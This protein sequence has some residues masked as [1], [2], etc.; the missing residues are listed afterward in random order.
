MEKIVVTHKKD[1]CKVCPKPS[2]GHCTF[3]K[4]TQ[5]CSNECLSFDWDA[6]HKEFCIGATIDT[7]KNT[8]DGIMAF[9]WR[10]LE[11]TKRPPHVLS[12]HAFGY[13]S[14]K[15]EF[16]DM[17]VQ[18]DLKAFDFLAFANA[19]TYK[20]ATLT[21]QLTA[22]YNSLVP[23]IFQSGGFNKSVLQDY[24]RK[25]YGG[26]TDMITA[27]MD[28]DAAV[29]ARGASS[30]FEDDPGYGYAKTG[31]QRHRYSLRREQ[32]RQPLQPG[33]SLEPWGS[34]RDQR[35]ILGASEYDPDE[36]E[37]EAE[38]IPLKRA[39]CQLL[40]TAA[41]ERALEKEVP[42]PVNPNVPTVVFAYGNPTSM[43]SYF[44]TVPILN[45]LLSQ[46]VAPELVKQL[47]FLEL[48]TEDYGVPLVDILSLFDTPRDDKAQ[49]YDPVAEFL[50][51]TNLVMPPV[52]LKVD[53]ADVNTVISEILRTPAPDPT[54]PDLYNSFEKAYGQRHVLQNAEAFKIYLEKVSGKIPT[55]QH[56][57]YFA[58]LARLYSVIDPTGE[59]P[60]VLLR[61]LAEVVFNITDSTSFKQWET[62]REPATVTGKERQ[63]TL[64]EGLDLVAE[65]KFALALF[66]ARPE[67]VFANEPY[68][69][70]FVE[71]L[72]QQ[73]VYSL[74]MLQTH[75]ACTLGN[76][77]VETIFV[78][79]VN[80]AL[81]PMFT[82]VFDLKGQRETRQIRNVGF[83]VMIPALENCYMEVTLGGT[84]Y[85][86]K[87]K[88]P[89]DLV[90]LEQSDAFGTFQSGSRFYRSANPQRF[91]SGLDLG[92]FM[93]SLSLRH[94]FG[95]DQHPI[96]LKYLDNERLA[97]IRAYHDTRNYRLTS[98]D[99]AIDFGIARKLTARSSA[100][101]REMLLTAVGK[102]LDVLVSEFHIDEDLENALRELFTALLQ[103]AKALSEIGLAENLK[104]Y[105]E[106]TSSGKVR[107]SSLWRWLT[108]YAPVAWKLRSIWK[109]TLD[110]VD[111]LDTTKIEGPLIDLINRLQ[112]ISKN[113]KET[114]DFFKIL[115][116]IVGYATNGLLGLFSEPW[117]LTITT[118]LKDLLFFAQKTY[119]VKTT[120]I[121]LS[122]APALAGEL[123]ATLFKQITTSRVLELAGNML[124]RTL[125][126]L[127]SAEKILLGAAM[128]SSITLTSPETFI[129]NEVFI[130]DDIP[131]ENMTQDRAQFAWAAFFNSVYPT[132]HPK[133]GPFP[134]SARG[135]KIF[136]DKNN[137]LALTD[138]L[139]PTATTKRWN[140]QEDFW[141][142][143]SDG[144][145]QITVLQGLMTVIKSPDKLSDSLSAIIKAKKMR[146][147]GGNQGQAFGAWTIPDSDVR[148]IVPGTDGLTRPRR[149]R[150]AIKITGVFPDPSVFTPKQADEEAVITV[151]GLNEVLVS[152]VTS[153]LYVQG[154]SPNFMQYYTAHLAETTGLQPN[155]QN[156]DA[157]DEFRSVVKDFA[158][159]FLS[160]EGDVMQ[161]LRA[162]IQPLAMCIGEW[163]LASQVSALLATPL[164][165]IKIMF[166]RLLGLSK[167]LDFEA[168]NPIT[169]GVLSSAEWETFNKQYEEFFPEGKTLVKF[170]KT[171]TTVGKLSGTVLQEAKSFLEQTFMTLYSSFQ[172]LW[173]ADWLKCL[174][175][176]HCAMRTLE[177]LPGIIGSQPKSWAQEVVE[178][179]LDSVAGVVG[180]TA[181]FRKF[182]TFMD[183]TLQ[184]IREEKAKLTKK[185]EFRFVQVME[186]IDG[187]MQHFNDIVEMLQDHLV[188]NNTAPEKIP[189]FHDYLDNAVAQII[190][191]LAQFQDHLQG[192]HDDFHAEN[193]M[194]KICDDTRFN[195]HALS[196][197]EH[198]DYDIN[199]DKIRIPNLGFIIKIAD[200]GL[201]S[202]NML[203]TGANGSINLTER[204][205]QF[206]DKKKETRQAGTTKRREQYL[207][208][209]TSKSEG[210]K[211]IFEH[212]TTWLESLVSSIFET[213]SLLRGFTQIDVGTITKRIAG[214]LWVRAEGAF[215]PS[216]DLAYIMNSLAMLPATYR[217]RI[218]HAYH[219]MEALKQLRE[220]GTLE[221]RLDYSPHIYSP[222]LLD[223]ASPI[224]PKA[225]LVTPHDFIKHAVFHMYRV[226]KD[227]KNAFQRTGADPITRAV[228]WEKNVTGFSSLQTT[229]TKKKLQLEQEFSKQLAKIAPE[230]LAQIVSSDTDLMKSFITAYRS[231]SAKNTTL[232]TSTVDMR[233]KKYEDYKEKSNR[234]IGFRGQAEKTE[235]KDI[236]DY[237]AQ[238]EVDITNILQNL[239]SM[240][241]V[242]WTEESY[243]NPPSRQEQS[244]AAAQTACS[245][246]GKIAAFTYLGTPIC[247]ATCAM[248]L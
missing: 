203:R 98:L 148:E 64:N 181:V 136:S 58:A 161:T 133:E 174:A 74:A 115:G 32:L 72:V 84:S 44:A 225:Q 122:D 194:I 41:S 201:S 195:G 127:L 125:A 233:L 227:G 211:A 48:V 129:E 16:I 135:A 63:D 78:K 114:N 209:H 111:A 85:Q 160:R 105:K 163:L 27:F 234:L 110:L 177:L 116:Y 91:Q 29:A 162:L 210:L 79:P 9:I 222:G 123:V 28:P 19:S 212:D 185:K 248:K 199:G 24:I 144:E 178:N 14:L 158:A 101:L 140:S 37:S 155:S 179:T 39:I 151:P 246:C 4:K 172:W 18:G 55:F 89:L 104:T 235:F 57:Q 226:G 170:T 76:I 180:G 15:D 128:P 217:S 132:A 242:T 207:T 12:E 106:L 131:P 171:A 10:V 81:C 205:R 183:G 3:C 119:A 192:M 93:N 220:T 35:T 65:F 184:Q 49:N 20:S 25:K 118:Y 159:L 26:R 112:Q 224:D 43:S 59:E 169:G 166:M 200:L 80:Q 121:S 156:A 124:K 214:R 193:V 168:L 244:P 36:T 66:Q 206:L 238:R 61:K 56:I 46:Y 202:V 88:S 167:S 45:T 54:A 75:F 154:I 11:G 67:M 137:E 187:D 52:G 237:A 17:L 7:T 40:I 73:I 13:I 186:A 103:F 197:Y 94:N 120:D 241:H 182:K 164:T 68:I 232:G 51:L 71:N 83:K 102:G 175:L 141:K 152:M 208:L 196:S 213:T 92:L 138:V 95:V 34:R 30:Y 96:V 70:V 77:G 221:G 108:V 173:E 60:T 50:M 23:S 198:F 109:R 134:M 86:V 147:G 42:V 143:L 139:D 69:L 142:G 113:E 188:K 126:R 216:F 229:L 21:A 247:D 165:K 191:A 223:F 31:F 236:A 228:D 219:D 243:Y 107:T 99:N 204:Q 189:R 190:C 176:I 33:M 97:H 8:Q 245:I 240:K 145:S 130:V 146:L 157:S 117:S 1:G 239:R 38:R 82:Y 87:S 149:E 47:P 6:G 231:W 100:E 22:G 53:R 90:I 5:Y 62:S 150:R 153:Q 218:V 230:N 215:I 2:A